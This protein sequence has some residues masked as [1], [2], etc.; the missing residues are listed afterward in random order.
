MK[1]L[2]SLLSLLL[3]LSACDTPEVEKITIEEGVSL[4]LAQYRKRV[5]S[6]VNYKLEF[7]V[8]KA[9]DQKIQ[10]LE[11]LT[12]NLTDNS[13]DILLDFRE[14]A[15]ML[16]FLEVNGKRQDIIFEKEHIVLPAE[17]LLKGR[18][19]VD[20]T[21]YAGETSLNRKEEFLYT[22]FVP[23][24]ART[25]FP[26]FDQPNLKATYE[27]IL[28]LPENWTAIAN[29]PVAISITRD[30]RKN[31]EF[32]KSDLMS[33]YLFSFV[34]GE[35]QRITESIGGREMTMLH[36][37]TDVEK[38]KRNKEFIFYLHGASLKWLEEYTGIKYP[39][40]KFDFALI[41]GFQYGG[42]EH[43]G[44]IQYRAS[45]LFL[46]E[47][48]SQNQ[49][50][51][52][53][54]LIAHETAHMWF[55]DLVTM[56]WFND[57]W[58]KEVFA[59]FMAAKMVNPSFPEINH[60]LSFLVRHYPSAYSVD[61]T[62]G[63]N[64]IRQELGNLNEAGQ[65]YGA[66]IYNKAPIMMRQLEMMLGEDAFQAGMQ[67]YLKTFANRNATWPDL[68][69]ILDKKT[70]QD[71]KTWSEVWVN[72]P[73]RPNFDLAFAQDPK[74][75]LCVS[76]HQSDPSGKNRL[77]QQSFAIARFDGSDGKR[78]TME[79]AE[80]DVSDYFKRDSKGDDYHGLI[81]ADGRGYGVF[82][83]GQ[84]PVMR[85]WT[86]L[87][88]LQK[89]V[90]MIDFYEQL[91][92]GRMAG[93][94]YI[95]LIKWIVVREKNQLL[96]NLVL[97]QLNRVYWSF[98]TPDQRDAL[99]PDLERTLYH[100]MND[101]AETPS[102]KKIFFNAFRNVTI[103]QVNIQRLY[104]IWIGAS[105]ARVPG[106][107]LSE[108]DRT[109]LAA[110]LAI[111]TPDRAEEILDKQLAA[112]ENPDRKKRFEFIMPSLSPD[113][114]KRDAFFASLKDETNRQ[115]ESWVLAALG[116]LH[117]PLRAQQSQKYIPESLELLEEIQKTGDIF[118]PKRWLDQT[119]N[120]H[121][122]AAAARAVREFLE[123]RPEYNA[124]LRMKIL[125]A[126]DMLFRSEKKLSPAM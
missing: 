108:R 107:R 88:D 85:N 77:W 76:L 99:A 97:G 56:D 94:E 41:P 63:A 47:N 14:S 19:T 16:Q 50:L 59:N 57:V 54:S 84:V 117:H 114:E 66:I 81:N 65:M 44:A 122:S 102:Q 22:L 33:T 3:V 72:T 83:L 21:F 12:F 87:G 48:P 93:D 121:N 96:L 116:Y 52:R 124:Q 55:G 29:A 42:M 69:D 32:Q 25:A 123:Q 82:N 125:Q 28:D 60:D 51:S 73:G 91:L 5:I 120:N 105:H 61:R 92:D 75:P 100:C 45:S 26:C 86:K 20:I 103:T 43:V 7:R 58:T 106:L 101:I 115:T 38:V 2:L 111:K 13:Q 126:A 6:S 78:L 112:I 23:D 98:L 46:D 113:I 79:G 67:E 109:S 80:V 30:G 70:E 104:N 15:D 95:A 27:L 89:G 40:K 24:R 34:A 9:S 36:R 35:F 11:T 17:T 10:S 8:P 4:E 90:A 53:A 118:F 74:C 1:Y 110:N 37:E 39:F 18:N 49:L 68:I 64:P 62:E 31:M 119:L 71:L